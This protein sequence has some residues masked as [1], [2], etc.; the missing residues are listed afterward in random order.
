[1]YSLTE[2]ESGGCEARTNSRG[3][4]RHTPGRDTEEMIGELNLALK[5]WATIGAVGFGTWLSTLS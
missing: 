5:G 2:Q 1:M 4:L 3:A